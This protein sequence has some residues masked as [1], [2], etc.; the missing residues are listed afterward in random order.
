MLYKEAGQAG[1][2]DLQRLGLGLILFMS[3]ALHFFRL[4]R[5]GEPVFHSGHLRNYVKWATAGN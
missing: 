3:L 5:E 2:I 1:E 4:D